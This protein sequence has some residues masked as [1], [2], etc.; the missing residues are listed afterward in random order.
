MSEYLW[1]RWR[2]VHIWFQRLSNIWT[3]DMKTFICTFP[4]TLQI[5]GAFLTIH[6]YFFCNC[7]PSRGHHII[8]LFFLF[9]S[10]ALITIGHTIYSVHLLHRTCKP[11][12]GQELFSVLVTAISLVPKKTLGIRWKVKVLVAQSCPTLCNCSPPVLCPWNFPGKNTGVAANPF[13]RR[14][15]LSNIHWMNEWMIDGYPLL[16]TYHL[17]ELCHLNLTNPVGLL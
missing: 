16:S 9:L 15:T 12:W 2:M 4:Q 10:L 17:H 6:D 14:Q 5:F 8:L 1:L 11:H 7:F 13:S 3:F